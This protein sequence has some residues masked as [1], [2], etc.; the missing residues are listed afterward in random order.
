MLF[1]A[2]S[3]CW[4]NTNTNRASFSK[5]AIAPAPARPEHRRTSGAHT[6]NA[7]SRE[8]NLTARFGHGGD[9]QHG[10]EGAEAEHHHHQA[11]VRP[12][13]G[14]AEK[15]GREGRVDGEITAVTGCTY[16]T[17]FQQ[18]EEWKKRKEQKEGRMNQ[19]RMNKS[20]KNE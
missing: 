14:G 19:G 13:S 18:K 17:T 7:R 4:C 20:R 8:V 12:G 11:V 5:V 6:R 1:S 10:Q 16:K 15:V 2:R 9:P 3:T